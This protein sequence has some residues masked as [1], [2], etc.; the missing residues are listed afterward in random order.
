M[1]RSFRSRLLAIDEV[2]HALL[3]LLVAL[4]GHCTAA[5]DEVFA[6]NGTWHPSTSADENAGAAGILAARDE[7][8]G[9]V[10]PTTCRSHVL[11][12]PNTYG[13]HKGLPST[14]RN[15]LQIS[16]GEVSP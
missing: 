15:P 7:I 2:S 1:E 13:L 5:A 11:K 8:R 9:R 12:L 16:C 10:S 3:K 4:G 6:E 14:S